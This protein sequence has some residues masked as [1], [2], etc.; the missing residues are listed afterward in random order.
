MDKS[1]SQ[2][3]GCIAP[4][5][6]LC[7]MESF[8]PNPVS[9]SNGRVWSIPQN[10]SHMLLEF[11]FFWDVSYSCTR[12][13]MMV[14]WVA[15][16]GLHFSQKCIFF[17]CLSHSLQASCKSLTRWKDCGCSSVKVKARSR[18]LKQPK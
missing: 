17:P 15:E 8:L 13:W 6:C 4:V 12:L 16:K 2:P 14:L 10:T 18:S 11:F 3:C 5:F 1:D 9:P 7:T